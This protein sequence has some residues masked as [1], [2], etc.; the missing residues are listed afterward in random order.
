MELGR[1]TDKFQKLVGVLYREKFLITESIVKRKP[2]I[3][4]HFPPE[5]ICEPTRNND[6]EIFDLDTEF[7]NEIH[8]PKPKSFVHPYRAHT[9]E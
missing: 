5:N 9:F 2:P 6:G 4:L 7:G 8:F 3:S 1:T